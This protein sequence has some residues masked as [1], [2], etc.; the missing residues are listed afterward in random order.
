MPEW[1]I[2][3]I[4]LGALF[5]GIFSGRSQVV[6]QIFRHLIS[7]A[8]LLG[9][10]TVTRSSN[11][12]SQMG[13]MVAQAM[14]QQSNEPEQPKTETCRKKST[15]TTGSETVSTLGPSNGEFVC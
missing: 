7:I 12:A 4:A 9:G 8:T 10:L 3:L 15:T 14:T 13:E 1:A 5:G 2:S 6:G 11:V